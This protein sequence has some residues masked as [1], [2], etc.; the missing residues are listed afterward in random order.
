MIQS[1]PF[2]CHNLTYSHMYLTFILF[3]SKKAQ[4]QV[5]Q[6]FLSSIVYESII[7]FYTLASQNREPSYFD[8]LE[9]R[10]K[11]EAGS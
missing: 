2:Q 8:I 4:F 6:F 1:P 7:Y 11:Q 5:V 3:D 9:S 10:T